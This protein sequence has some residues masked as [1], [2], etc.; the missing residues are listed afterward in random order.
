MVGMFAQMTSKLL[1][2]ATTHDVDRDGR[3]S[4]SVVDVRI[5]DGV[6]TEVGDLARREDESVEDLSGCVLLPAAVEPHAHLDKAFLA[7]RITNETG[8]LMGAIT[9]MQ[10]SRHLLNVDE[11]IE[12]AER[13]A[14]LMA[15]NGYHAVRSHAD[16]T[17]AHGLCSIEALVEVKRRVA[18][19]ID[20][21]I[22]ALCGWPMTG[23]QCAD[24][25]ALLNEAMS[26]GADLV[27]GV[28]HLEGDADREATELLLQIATDHGVGV[29]LHTDE[30][31]NTDVLGLVDLAELVL[32]GFEHPV[33]ASHCVSLGMQSLSRQQEVAELVARAGISVVALPHTNLFLQGRGMAPMPRALTAVEALRTAGVTVAAGADNL[34]D[35]FNP[36]GR[37]C[38]FETAGLMIM[39]AHLLPEDAW[40]SVSTQSARATGRSAVAVAPGSPAHLVAARSA[41]IREAIAF[42]PADRMVWR[43]GVRVTR[44][45]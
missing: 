36:V 26:A 3:R 43:S 6:I 8:D 9:A 15:S 37:A 20:L 39:T 41:T 12:R 5:V 22:V 18:D 28:P 24:Q 16:T 32:G 33:T 44:G 29:D 34:Q 38:P 45:H 19:V 31:T 21:E 7:E 1:Q 10:A 4:R 13:A 2:R 23:P 27:G 14:R 35:P 30:T 42:G 25:R 17:I 40:A 11:T